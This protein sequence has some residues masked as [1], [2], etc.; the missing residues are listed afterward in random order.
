MA[1]DHAV[2]RKREGAA[3]LPRPR[4]VVVEV[5][6]EDRECGM[7][8]SESFLDSTRRMVEPWLGLRLVEAW[9]RNGC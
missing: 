6:L 2:M 9:L 1:A 7:V 8:M 4:F 3:Y 5:D